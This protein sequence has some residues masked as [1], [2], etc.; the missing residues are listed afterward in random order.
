MGQWHKTGCVLCAQ[1]CGLEV[2]V[3]NNRI[4][5][6]K[7]D[8]D[9]P[10]SKGYVCR[11]GANIAFY[12]HHSGRLSHPLK[13]VGSSFERISWDEAVGE[14]SEKL[15]S[16]VGTYGPKSFAYMGGGG[17]GCH[18]EAAF[19]VRLLRAL[20]S[21]YHYSA[22][23]QELTGIFWASGRFTGKQYLYAIP[24]EHRSDMILAIGWNGMQSHQMP[25]APLVLR[26]F[27]KNPDKLL[28]VIDPR[29]SET[30]EIADIH[31]PVRPGTDALL[32]RAMIAIL[33]KEDW[34]DKEYIDRHVSGFAE[35]EP[36]F[37]DFDAEAAVK[38]CG[39]DFDQVREVCRLL[40][41][42]KWCMHTDLGI[43]MNR[44]STVASYLHL[45]MAALCGRFC[46]AGGNVIPGSIMPLGAHT[47]E[48]DPKTWRTV[49]TGFPALMGVF[50]PN[51]M[52]E[53]I[54]SDNPERLRAVLCCQ[55]NPLR[56]FAD[57]TAY[58]QAFQKLD[59][60]VTCELAMTETA[61][62]SHY[63]LPALSAY[64]SWDA[65]F[66]AWTFPEIYFQMRRPILEPEGERCELSRIHVKLADAL[67]LIPAIPDSL[68]NAARGDRLAFG[69]ELMKYAGE[70]PRALPNMQYVLAKTLG[71][72]LGSA[73]LAALWGM[74]Q[75]APKDFRRCAARA[76]FTP[77]PTMGE[78]IF[79]AV[80]D[81]PEGLIIG[82]A[83][84]ENNF[85][86]LQTEDG[87]VNIHIPE[88]AD[89]VKSIAPESEEKA[90]MPD[91]NYPLIL[92]A[93][94]H[95]SMNANT[96]MRDPAWNEGKRDCTVLVH[97]A[98]AA[99]LGI[100]DGQMVRVSTEAGRVEIEAE[101]TEATRQGQVII[102]HG[103]GMIHDGR[104]HGANVN[105]LTK[106]TY[107][108]RFA[109]TPLHRY[110]RCRI[111][112]V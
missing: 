1:N 39:L 5:K 83:D 20:G 107:R 7:G 60:L 3:E 31:L 84:P 14:I 90:L 108:D 95:M 67:G 79:R 40:S 80:I 38:V 50:P 88:M 6:V 29:K 21:R 10:R 85:S 35:I 92:Q 9:N 102:P 69:M 18:F 73:N 23:G 100:I 101:I 26:E 62:L 109:G 106:N 46:V 81:H 75:V 87:R 13:K 15:R 59:L 33:L 16:I 98:D 94:R 45:A 57:T 78:D 66:F 105:R 19:G 64:E 44:H 96:I 70:E 34:H 74:L 17:Q 93:G 65:T 47:D 24:D 89:W 99:G 76:G 30:A 86:S 42:R 8:K 97:P 91:P 37:K 82:K 4:S 32:T 12:Q 36:W 54:L 61:A 43:Y 58:E 55:S 28:V 25:R 111:E 48:R 11:K 72:H 2:F 110:V 77:G 71:E 112:A 52:P 41:T 56:S 104:E 22:L 68:K 51:V 53:E 49:A 103:F 63:V 27:S